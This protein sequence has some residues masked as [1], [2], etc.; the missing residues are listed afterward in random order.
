MHP[1]LQLS[2]LNHFGEKLRYLEKVYSFGVIIN[3][4]LNSFNISFSLILI[5]DQSDW[6]D[7]APLKHLIQQLKKVWGFW[8]FL[9]SVG[10]RDKK[11]GG[12][13]ACVCVCVCYLNN[14]KWCVLQYSTSSPEKSLSEVINFWIIKKIQI[15][16]TIRYT[17]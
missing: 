9:D 14:H 10:E 15:K 5:V 12:L 16:T 8:V 3:W 6:P 4:K 2:L 13:C 7:P 11:R 1:C 17:L